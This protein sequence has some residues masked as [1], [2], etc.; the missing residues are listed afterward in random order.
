MIAI[1]CTS[2][3]TT[4]IFG[5]WKWW[6]ETCCRVAC[7]KSFPDLRPGSKSSR[8]PSNF[9]TRW[10][11]SD[12]DSLSRQRRT[13]CPFYCSE[14]GHPSVRS[15]YY[16]FQESSDRSLSRRCQYVGPGDHAMARTRRGG[17][18]AANHRSDRD[19][20]E[21]PPTPSA[22]TLCFIGRVVGGQF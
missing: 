5:E 6:V 10:S 13:E 17:G 20:G 21:R 19:P 11:N 1:G 16:R 3:R 8:T 7:K 4:G 9:R 12:N 14:R 2:P 22:C 15:G 18:G